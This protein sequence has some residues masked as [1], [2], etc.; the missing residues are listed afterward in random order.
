MPAALHVI[1][2]YSPMIQD[3]RNS[4][5]GRTEPPGS[6]H[7]GSGLRLHDEEVVLR[8]WAT[9]DAPAIE[10][11]CGEWNVCQFSV[12]WAYTPSAARGWIDR[13]RDRRLSGSGLALAVTVNS[14]V[15]VGNVNPV[16]FSDDGR[17]AAVGYW[18]LPAA[19]G[20]GLAVRPAVGHGHLRIDRAVVGPARIAT[21]IQVRAG[22]RT[23]LL[24]PCAHACRT[25]ARERRGPSSSWTTI[26]I[27]R[28]AHLAVTARA[29]NLA[30]G[31]TVGQVKLWW[32]LAGLVPGCA[33]CL[34]RRGKAARR[35]GC[36]PWR[37]R[38]RV[39]RPRW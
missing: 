29:A 34:G 24:A 27:E 4:H 21:A 31:C 3:A 23:S 32:R 9:Q 5:K 22:G 11:V 33:S 7:G 38:A 2:P 8:D 36:W 37:L 18:L 1:V 13:Q 6:R 28:C 39:E 16:R 15:L 10:P 17:E 12:P 20:Q 26:A 25:R 19:R 14:G 35:R 30:P